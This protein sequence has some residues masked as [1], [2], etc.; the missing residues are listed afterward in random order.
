MFLLNLHRQYIV[1]VALLLLSFSARHACLQ[2]GVDTGVLTKTFMNNRL[3]FL[4]SHTV[5]KTP[6][7]FGHKTPESSMS[8][9][10]CCCRS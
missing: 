9:P 7:N 2:E 8:L 5:N 4:V 3:T 1:W 10:M 6:E